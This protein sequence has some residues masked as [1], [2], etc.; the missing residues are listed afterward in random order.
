[1]LEVSASNIQS[2]RNARIVSQELLPPQMR[3]AGR[4]RRHGPLLF[5][6]LAYLMITLAYSLLIPAWEANDEADHVANAQYI[7]EHG[8]LPPLRWQSWHETHQPPLY[9]IIAAAWQRALGIA[10][11]THELP[12]PL[13]LPLTGPDP[14]LW[15]SHVY[16]PEQRLD[17]LAVHK[18]RLVSVLFGLG[19][20]AL[21]YV[22]GS[23][24][25]GQREIAASAAGFVAFLP[26]FNVVSAAFTNDSL[27]IM[28]CSLGLVLALAYRRIPH[29]K[30]KA[31]AKMALAIC[32]G[33]TAGA[34]L[35]TKLNSLPVFAVLLGSLL[36]VRWNDLSAALRDVVI[37][38]I[39]LILT[40]GW[41]LRLNYRLSGDLLGQ[42]GVH[43]WLNKVLPGNISIV[44]WTDSERFLNFVPHCLFQSI[45]YDGAWNQFLAP[46]A[47]NLVLTCIASV[48][49][50]GVLKAFVQ[51]GLY[52]K[53]RDFPI[54]LLM[55]CSLAA[56]AVVFIIAKSATQAEGRLAYVGLT[57]FALL[58][59]LGVAE[60]I[61]DTAGRLRR[62]AA[63]WP[64][65]LLVFNL[66][67]FLRFVLPFRAL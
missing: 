23:L 5:V 6:C 26:K 67:V 47:F 51:G 56:L 54:A 10:P 7:V 42:K 37:A 17:A 27:V 19:T 40:A 31:P 33:M 29:E 13:G 41:W 53:K 57:A 39:G 25:C 15:F 21:T 43:D 18:L 38:A 64:I 50:F 44:P 45:W 20:V 32:L 62:A 36:I 14:H 1:L 4:L 8:K 60:A 48:A 34:A 24:V 11:F 58:S 49:L 30:T 59:V 9:Y 46:F 28:L 61:G 52:I 22:A 65:V 66:Y 12:P 2:G 3:L 16:S 55:T 35:I 63:L